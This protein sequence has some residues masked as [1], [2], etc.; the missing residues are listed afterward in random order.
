MVLPGALSDPAFTHR[1]NA[2]TVDRFS[3]STIV[4]SDPLSF[5]VD[6]NPSTGAV[7]TWTVIAGDAAFDLSSAATII[8]SGLTVFQWNNAGLTWAD[9]DKVS[10][11]MRVRNLAATGAPAVTGAAQAGELLTADVSGIADSNG[12]PEDALAYQWVVSDGGTDTEVPGADGPTYLPWDEDIGKSVKVR[13]SFTDG[14]G[15]AESRTSP[16]T[17]A[18]AA[19]PTGPVI[20]SATLTVGSDFAGAFLGLAPTIT[21]GALSDPD[22]DHRST[23]Y[24][25]AVLRLYSHSTLGTR[26]SFGVEP[27]FSTGSLDTWTLIV[28][29]IQFDLFPTLSLVGDVR[30]VIWSA[31]SLSWSPGDKVSVGVRVRN[32][33]AEGAPIVTGSPWVGETL[34]ADPSGISDKNGIPGDTFTY[35]WV[36]S[37]GTT[38]TDIAGATE[39]AY[40]LT[41]AEVDKTVRVRVSFTDADGFVESRTSD[42][43]GAV[44]PPP[45]PNVAATGA[46]AVSGMAQ[47]GE[48]LTADVSGIADENGVPGDTF[49]Y[50][51]IVSDGGTDTEVPGA[52]GPTY[53]PWDADIGKTVKVRV[54]FTDSNGYAEGPFTSAATAAV[55]E[56]PTGPVIW[57]ATLTAGGMVEVGYLRGAY[58]ALSDLAFT[59]RS[60]AHVVRSFNLD[61]SGGA[62]PLRFVVD[63]NASAGAVDTL[64]LIAGDAEFDLS[65]AGT[66]T[67]VGLTVFQWNNAGLT[68][69]DGD[70][71]SVGM[72]VRNL[73]ATGAPIVSGTA[74]AG[75]LL[76]ADTTGIADANGIP[77]DAL[78]YQWIV[79]DGGTD[80]EVPGADGPT[81]LPWD[82]DIGKAVK[83]RVSFTDG[84]GF[85]EGPFTSAA[86]AAV[87]ASPTGPVIWSATLTVG[88]A[89]GGIRLGL[90]PTIT[91]G[92]LSDPDFDHRSTSYTVAVTQTTLTTGTRLSFGV[93]PDFSTGAADTWTLIVGDIQFD[94]FPILGFV[95][96]VPTVTWDAPSLSWSPGDKVSVGV[97]VRNRAAEGAPIV[98]GTAQVGHTL[99]VDVSGIED[100]NGVPDASALSYQWVANDGTTDADVAGADGQTYELTD[101]DKG[102]TI[103]V[104]VSFTDADGFPE[105]PFTSDP[106]ARVAA[107]NYPATGA[108]ALWG[109]A[110]VGHTLWVDL[111]LVAS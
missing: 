13:V 74:Q 93:E 68:W 71:V 65:I 21:G 43:T 16:P 58:G 26:L 4:S 25:V 18:V 45:A 78:A 103:R 86:T 35:Q 82:E 56:S 50:Q 32:R 69:A 89:S 107:V 49:T 48:L 77:E 94:L 75:E 19:S 40:T 39:S 41:G 33:A 51:W 79:S 12:V 8:A 31:S 24:A 110:Q 2:H 96:D 64:T 15:F 14:D 100:R 102:K 66:T 101:A 62:R 34:T 47:A 67:V 57:S 98:R 70:K 97:Q 111:L 84:N 36:A 85:D 1:L 73:A 91:G 42:P 20:W 27:D 105:G 23:S 54:S 29:D 109:I 38:D 17:A 63:P 76:S 59:H 80:T 37:D 11:G 10:A 44:T 72:R 81:Y 83:V 5:A 53:L 90:T 87:T 88:S 30:T 104:R 55:T 9:G 3:L 7:D 61:L 108:P 95:G 28:G 99:R 6:P 46:P 22:F 92:G 106:T 60:N 52:D